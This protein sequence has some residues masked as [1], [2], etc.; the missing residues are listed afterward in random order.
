MADLLAAVLVHQLNQP[1]AAILGNAQ[2]ALRLL[3]R[4]APDLALLREMLGDIVSQ[5]RQA[6]R[7]I[8]GLPA[9]F[10]EGQTQWRA[11][12]PQDIARAAMRALRTHLREFGIACHLQD[13]QAGPSQLRVHGDRLHLQQ[14]LGNLL[15]NA[16]DAIRAGGGSNGCIQICIQRHDREVC[17]R[18]LDNGPGID[19]A[20]LPRL[21]EAFVSTRSQGMGIGLSIAQAIVRRHGG[22]IEASNRAEG[23]AC[24]AIIL[25]AWPLVQ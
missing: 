3:A 20:V 13:L 23:G 15:C 25:P 2:A 4:P 18:V 6:A 17:L 1:L 14:A 11:I 7:L 5:E 8:T 19:P 24:F 16:C 21:F 12:I 22:R 10:A 9:L